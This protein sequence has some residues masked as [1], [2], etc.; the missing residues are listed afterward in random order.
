[1]M[2]ESI[3]VFIYFLSVIFSAQSTICTWC[4]GI[5]YVIGWF[6][7]FTVFIGGLKWSR[8]HI[9]AC[10]S[11]MALC[12]YRQILLC[13]QGFMGLVSVENPWFRLA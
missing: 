3:H 7:N 4:M 10:G 11:V 2:M 1:M 12:F 8:Y 5:F 6:R 13:Q 9:K